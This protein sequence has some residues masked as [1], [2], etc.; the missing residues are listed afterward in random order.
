MRIGWNWELAEQIVML[1]FL[2]SFVIGG[3]KTTVPR[4]V[5]LKAL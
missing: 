5:V 1:E 3:F 2:R 4:M